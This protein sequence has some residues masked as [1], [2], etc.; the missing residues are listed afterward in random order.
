MFWG[1]N[2]TTGLA[3]KFAATVTASNGNAMAVRASS[4]SPVD[5]RTQNIAS[6]I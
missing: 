4:P 6:M 1:I 2:A 3:C 5:R